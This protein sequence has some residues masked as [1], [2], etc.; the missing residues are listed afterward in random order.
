MFKNRDTA[1][2]PYRVPSQPTKLWIK[3]SLVILF[4]FD[5]GLAGMLIYTSNCLD[6][7]NFVSLYKLLL[8]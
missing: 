8:L 6:L 1:S 5:L 3:I 2:N 7:Y 4:L